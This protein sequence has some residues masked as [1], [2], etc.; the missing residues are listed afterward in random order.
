VVTGKDLYGVRIYGPYTTVPFAI[1]KLER[2]SEKTSVRT[3]S[4]ASRGSAQEILADARFLFPKNVI[5]QEGDR[6]EFGD[7]KLTVVSVWPRYR[8]TGE[9]DHWQVDCNIWSA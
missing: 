4:S 9:L 2:S 8:V 6:V 5:V 1:V 7:F 3:D